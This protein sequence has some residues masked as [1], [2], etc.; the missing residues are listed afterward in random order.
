LIHAGDLVG[1]PVDCRREVLLRRSDGNRGNRVTRLLQEVEVSER[2]ASLR[3]RRVAKQATHV[4]VALDVGAPREV[5]VATVRLRLT[6]E[7]RLQVLVGVSPLERLGHVIASS[8][9]YLAVPR[10]NH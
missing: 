1:L 3:L 4:R 10:S 8:A 2:V 7:R 6:G 9:G 5:K